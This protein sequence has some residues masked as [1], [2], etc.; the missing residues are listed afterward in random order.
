MP[1]AGASKS[2]RQFAARLKRRY[3]ITVREFRAKIEAQGGKCPICDKRL[4]KRGRGGMCVDHNHR[5]GEFRG[6]LCGFY[7]N[8]RVVGGVERCG[9]ARALAACRYLGYLP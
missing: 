8:K 4:Q 3:G 2:Q 1:A 7:C 6:V 9:Q 5:T